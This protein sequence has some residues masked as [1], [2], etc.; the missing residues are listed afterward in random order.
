MGQRP[1]QAPPLPKARAAAWLQLPP[2]AGSRRAR[3][4]V[5]KEKEGRREATGP[6]PSEPAAPSL[7]RQ[8]RAASQPAAGRRRVWAGGERG[9]GRAG[10]GLKGREEKVSANPPAIGC[11]PEQ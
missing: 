11:Y 2:P 8:G 7:Q 4:A 3:A 10:K 1:C 6:A 9:G 5:V